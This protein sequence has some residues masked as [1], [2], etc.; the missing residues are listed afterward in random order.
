MLRRAVA[1]AD[2]VGAELAARHTHGGVELVLE[3]VEQDVQGGALAAR[4]VDDR[5]HLDLERAGHDDL[6]GPAVEHAVGRLLDLGHGLDEG[7]GVARAL[8]H[9]VQGV[10]HHVLVERGVGPQPIPEIV[11][12]LDVAGVLLVGREHRRGTDTRRI[13]ADLA[14]RVALLDALRV[15]AARSEGAAG[16]VGHHAVRPGIVDAGV[17]RRLRPEHV[18]HRLRERGEVDDGVHAHV[19]I[20]VVPGHV[21]RRRGRAQHV[22]RGVRR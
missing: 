3:I 22:H 18:G 17:V 1:V 14:E 9:A 16:A 19:G 6:V 13:T 12:Q 11:E 10:G 21:A 15:V 8:V 5:G 4:V 7:G 20:D 2:H